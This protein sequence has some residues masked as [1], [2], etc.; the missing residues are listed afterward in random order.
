MSANAAEEKS[1]PIAATLKPSK[2]LCFMTIPM[3]T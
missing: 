2:I 1:K 3:W